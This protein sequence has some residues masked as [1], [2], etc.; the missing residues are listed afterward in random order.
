[1]TKTRTICILLVSLFDFSNVSKY[2]PC[3]KAVDWFSTSILLCSSLLTPFMNLQCCI[4]CLTDSACSLHIIHLLT[5]CHPLL[6]RL[7]SVR[8]LF[9]SISQPNII[10]LI[11]APISIFDLCL[12]Q[13]MAPTGMLCSNS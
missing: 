7:S 13:C 9:F 4:I 6:V 3:W 8:I 2:L 5:M 1:M 12:W 11:G 10:T